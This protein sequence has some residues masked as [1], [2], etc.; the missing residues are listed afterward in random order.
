MFNLI[1]FIQAVGVSILLT[2]VVSFVLGFFS[3]GNY[4]VFILIQTVLTYGSLG[5]F[6]A[7]WNP[8]TPYTAAYFGALLISFLSL[9]LSHFV[10]NIL[11]F[12]DPEGISRSMSL[13]VIVS[14]AFAAVTV[15][16]QTKRE[17]VHP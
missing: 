2:V 15:F 1:K 3:I 14:L 6:T 16:I 17:G 10:F 5:F 13:A 8:K 7:K 11:V 4:G 9:L 12:V